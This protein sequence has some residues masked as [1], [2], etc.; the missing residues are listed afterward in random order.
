MAD[1]PHLHVEFYMD[2]KENPAKSRQ[3]GRPIFEEVEMVK[4]QIVGDPKN[5]L[6]APAQSASRRHPETGEAWTY[7]EQYPEHYRYFRDHLDQSAADGTPL[8][9]A[10]W[11]SAAQRAELKALKITTI[12]GLAGLDGTPLSRIGM[13]GR[14]LKNKAQAW[15]DAAAGNAPVA[16]MVEEL[17]S[18]DAII[19]Q[20][21][22]DMAALMAGTVAPVKS[23]P[24]PDAGDSPFEAWDDE[25]IKNWIKDQTGNRP[26]GNPAHKTLVARADEINDELRAAQAKA[27]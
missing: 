16:R 15:L 5:S 14:E 17:A 8:S 11:L 1:T 2:T 24:E 4:I 10:P 13:G 27:A 3:E 9:E 26:L 12:E 21:Q 20:L 19:A 7:A 25:D 23:E 18:R 6:I 22:A